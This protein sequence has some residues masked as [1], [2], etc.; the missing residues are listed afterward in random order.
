MLRVIQT[1]KGKAILSFTQ[2]LYFAVKARISVFC[3]ECICCYGIVHNL[4][5]PLLKGRIGVKV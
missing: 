1:A 3:P 4:H 5:I 2:C